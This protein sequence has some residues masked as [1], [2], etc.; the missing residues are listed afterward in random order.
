MGALGGPEILIVAL[1]AIVLFGGGKLAELGKGLG[2][3][4]SELRAGLREGPADEPA[5]TSEAAR[6]DAKRS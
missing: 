5:P 1:V 6:H 2:K 4:I 3:G